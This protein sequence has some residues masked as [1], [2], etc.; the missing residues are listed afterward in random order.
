MSTEQGSSCPLERPGAIDKRSF[1][2]KA[3]RDDST[4]DEIDE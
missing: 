1:E 4:C 3:V 2:E